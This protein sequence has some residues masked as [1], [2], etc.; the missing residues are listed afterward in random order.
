MIVKAKSLIM[1][2]KSS[3][4]ALVRVFWQSNENFYIF[5]LLK[6]VKIELK[7]TCQSFFGLYLP[8]LSAKL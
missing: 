7:M 3:I 2:T 8:K 4:I 6:I 1:L 5:S